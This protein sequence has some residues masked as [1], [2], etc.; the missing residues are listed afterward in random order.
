[1]PGPKKQD[2]ERKV[3]VL[4][5]A[6]MDRLRRFQGETGIPSEVE[7]TRFLLRLGLDRHDAKAARSSATSA[8]D[9]LSMTCLIVK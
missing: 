2:V 3:Y 5:R 9:R 8:N 6:L 4:P 7:T 1:M